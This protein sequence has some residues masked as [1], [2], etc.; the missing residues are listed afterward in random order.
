M[1]T[2]L[3]Y[4]DVVKQVV[5]EWE[6]YIR[7]ARHNGVEIQRIFDDGNNNY[8][9]MYVGWDKGRRVERSALHLRIKDDKIWIEADETD[10]GIADDLLRAGVPREDIV[11]GFQP[12][13]MR[14]LS[15]FGIDPSR[16][17]ERTREIS[18]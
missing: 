7:R 14:A 18:G 16:A 12:P 4:R 6:S 3:D 8:L 11:L 1:D 13:E 2:K 5:V 17:P 9:L 15:E 10:R